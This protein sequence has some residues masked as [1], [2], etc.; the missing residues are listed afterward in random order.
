MEADTLPTGVYGQAKV[1]TLHSTIICSLSVS[2]SITTVLF[3][4]CMPYQR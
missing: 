2:S 1:I 4:I 3:W